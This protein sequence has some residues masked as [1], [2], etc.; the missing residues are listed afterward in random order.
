MNLCRATRTKGLRRS[1]RVQNFA[2]QVCEGH[3]L[4]SSSRDRTAKVSLCSELNT[5]C[6]QKSQP[7]AAPC[8]TGLRRSLHVQKS[9]NSD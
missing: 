4:C 8:A 5:T 9:Q 7:C 3:S 1:L 2:Q 6:V